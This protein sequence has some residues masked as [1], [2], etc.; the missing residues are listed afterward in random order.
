MES[1]HIV[2]A[3]DEELRKLDTV[4]AEM[5]GLAESQLSEAIQALIKRDGEMAERVAAR[6]GRID[7]LERE[8]NS[9]AIRILALRQPMAED[10]RT[11]IAAL[12]T[13]NDLE[14]IG[15]YI[16]NMCMRTTAVAQ[17]P[18]IGGGANTIARMG[19]LVQEMIKNVLDAYINRD[20]KMAEDVRLRD[21]EV[22]QIHN[23]LFRELLTYMIEDPRNI[24]TC[25]HLLFIAK[26]I[27]RIGDHITDV[28][29]HVHLMV[30]GEELEPGRPKGDQTSFTVIGPPESE[31][32]VD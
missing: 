3:Y 32:G 27:E 14:R 9:F 23:S 19:R 15:D 4:I 21:Q 5:G 24:T 17:T 18:P 29:E 25:T 13:A 26:N 12:K 16:R 1:G 6:D 8:V 10:L 30:V 20:A 22:D 7:E 11:V 31:D 28:A 2:K